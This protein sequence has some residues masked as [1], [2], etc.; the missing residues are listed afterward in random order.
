M[1]FICIGPVCIPWTCL[2][3]IV[4]FLWKFVKPCMP[5][6]AAEWCEDKGRKVAKVCQ[7]YIDK[8]YAACGMGKKKKVE[9]IGDLS[10]N[11]INGEVLKLSSDAHFDLLLERSKKEGFGIVLD[12]TA[13][14][15]KPCKR[16]KPR[17]EE[18][19]KEHKKH[20]FVMV[21]QE[22]CEDTVSRCEVMGLPTFQVWL[23]GE[24]SESMSGGDE[25]AEAKLVSMLHNRL[26]GGDKKS[27]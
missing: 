15:C 8:I 3:A 4:F 21:D 25:K 13:T 23:D 2:P 6:V 16:I 5:E 26:V 17:F 22:E 14:W 19:A 18:L 27:S 24:Q 12:F 10:A 9:N 11:F 1:P 7:P 20:C